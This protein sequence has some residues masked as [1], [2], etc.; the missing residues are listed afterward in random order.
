MKAKSAK[1]DVVAHSDCL[2]DT[3]GDFNNPDKRENI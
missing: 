2:Q 1:E 3:E